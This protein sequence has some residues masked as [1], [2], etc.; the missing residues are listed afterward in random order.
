MPQ[1]YPLEQRTIGRVLAD[2]AQRVPQR[3]FLRW[4]GAAFTY[5]E[6]GRAHV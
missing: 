5:A 4:Q 3:T 6:I 1:D 2:K